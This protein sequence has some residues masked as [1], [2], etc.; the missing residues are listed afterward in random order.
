LALE[1]QLVPTLG[2][3]LAGIAIVLSIWVFKRTLDFQAYREMD[4][5]YMEILK[6]GLERP[7][8]RDPEKTAKYTDLTGDDKL[9]YEAYAY[10]VWN[11]C[12]TVYDRK[13]VDKTWRP[14]LIEENRLLYAWLT[15]SKNREKFKPKFIKYIEVDNIPYRHGWFAK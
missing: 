6:I 7:F 3:I 11:L 10:L 5:N 9:R 1:E 4:S 14:V 12:E 13:M 8:L 15:D 2:P